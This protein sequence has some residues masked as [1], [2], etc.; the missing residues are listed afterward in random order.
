V[1]ARRTTLQLSSQVNPID[2]LTRVKNK[3]IKTYDFCFQLTEGDAFIGCSPERLFKKQGKVIY[4]EALA[5]TRLKGVSDKEQKQFYKELTESPKEQLEHDYVFDEVKDCLNDICSR[6]Q[7]TGQRD[8]LS[9]SY[10]Q[11]FCSRFEGE[12]KDGIKNKDIINSLHPTA[13]VNGFP[14]LDARREID[15]YESFSRG[16]FAGPV[17]WIDRQNADFAVAIRSALVTKKQIS[18]FAGAGLVESSDPDLEWQETEN[19]IK[20]FLDVIG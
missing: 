2:I 10:L 16:W 1:L 11:H 15:K 13:A 4:S 3:N 14:R 7:V 8:V 17:G 19:K 6:M 5:G 18:L 9:L 20:Q 12:L